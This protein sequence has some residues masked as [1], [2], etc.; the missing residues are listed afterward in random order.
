MNQRDEDVSIRFETTGSVMAV[1]VHALHCDVT[2]CNQHFEGITIRPSG[3][4]GMKTV[5]TQK[6]SPAIPTPLRQDVL[7]RFFFVM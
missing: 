3:S 7:L 6:R 4:S 1:S 5:T 2:G